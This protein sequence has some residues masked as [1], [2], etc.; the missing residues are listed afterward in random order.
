[1][2]FIIFL[3]YT[4]STFCNHDKQA[5]CSNQL[6]IVQQ[7]NVLSKSIKEKRS[8]DYGRETDDEWRQGNF[9]FPDSLRPDFESSILKLFRL[10]FQL[11][12][13]QTSA[14]V[15]G[16][17]SLDPSVKQNVA[18]DIVADSVKPMIDGE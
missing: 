13:V 12:I 18:T 7:L 2:K 8:V 6:N 5:A 10:N 15:A 11:I 9:G 14:T 4:V 17:C 3:F 1:M 16:T